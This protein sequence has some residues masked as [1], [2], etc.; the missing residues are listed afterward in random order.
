MQVTLK[1]A[2]SRSRLADPPT[3]LAAL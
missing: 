1:N 3:P 2:K